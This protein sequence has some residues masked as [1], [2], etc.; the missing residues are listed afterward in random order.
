MGKNCQAMSFQAM[1]RYLCCFKS[2][3]LAT[4]YDSITQQECGSTT[5]DRCGVLDDG[6][7]WEASV[8]MGLGKPC[9]ICGDEARVKTHAAP[10]A[11][12]AC[13]ACWGKWLE[14]SQRCMVCNAPCT[15]QNIV[16]APQSLVPVTA[17]LDATDDVV[18]AVEAAVSALVKLKQELSEVRAKLAEATQYAQDASEADAETKNAV[19]QV[20]AACIV[21]QMRRIAEAL[22]ASNGWAS[23]GTCLTQATRE[24]SGLQGELHQA[25]ALQEH[26]R[27]RC[28]TILQSSTKASE[29]SAWKGQWASIEILRGDIFQSTLPQALGAISDSMADEAMIQ[30]VSLMDHL[31]MG[32][33][34]SA[35]KVDEAIQHLEK[36]SHA[37]VQEL[38]SP[39]AVSFQAVGLLTPT[40]RLRHDERLMEKRQR[41]FEEEMASLEL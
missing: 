13:K 17:A 7:D 41:I 2:N 14:Q 12:S 28:K 22:E 38:P 24:I 30:L 20:Q 33:A 27:L 8:S 4:Q 19:M 39:T 3:L 29:A 25:W 9:S 15:P 5:S 6:I 1:R 32:S 36:E 34:A 16:Q 10:C 21:D 26:Q 11:H 18:V 31:S 35:A 23:C 40:S 37:L